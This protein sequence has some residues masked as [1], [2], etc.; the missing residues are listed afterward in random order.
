MQPKIKE[1]IQM[2]YIMEALIEET[3]FAKIIRIPISRL[4]AFRKEHCA[5]F[6][7]IKRKVYYDRDEF[8]NWFYNEF[9]PNE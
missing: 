4:R 6:H 9:T 8:F 2:Y 5:P 7:R 3:E 1:E